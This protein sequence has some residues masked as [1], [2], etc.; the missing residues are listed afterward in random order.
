MRDEFSA[1]LSALARREPDDEAIHEARKSVKKIRSILRLLRDDLGPRGTR[2]EARLRTA[3]HA[4][5]ALRDADATAETLDTLHGRYPQVVDGEVRRAVTRGL[6]G[7][8]RRTRRGAG[9]LA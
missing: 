6:R 9:L 7:R 5:S 2:E 4:L 1:A 3:A 8:Q